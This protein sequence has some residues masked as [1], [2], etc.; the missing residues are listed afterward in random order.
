MHEDSLRQPAR[1]R[2]L[3]RRGTAPQTTAED[4]GKNASIS[5]RC[6]PP[7]CVARNSPSSV[8]GA[9]DWSRQF[10][11]SADYPGHIARAQ[12]AR[13]NARGHAL[14]TARCRAFRRSDGASRNRFEPNLNQL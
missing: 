14:S 1:P 10:R 3:A 7:D 13:A 5:K 12:K 2:T 8:C 11:S 6:D 9:L 4:Q